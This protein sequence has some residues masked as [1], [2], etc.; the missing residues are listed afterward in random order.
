M[1]AAGTT[2]G[3]RIAIESHLD[4]SEARSL[5]EDVRAGLAAPLKEIPPKHFYDTHGALLFERIC[6]L[7]EYYQTRTERSILTAHAGRIAQLTEASELL[8]L[9]SGSAS[10]TRL[11]IAPLLAQGTLRRYIPVDCTEKMVRE[12][13][14]ELAGDYPDLEVH[15][16]IADFERHLELLPASGGR[17][18]TIFLGGTIGNFPPQ[19]RERFLAALA[20]SM[21]GDDHLLI[22]VDL[23]KDPAVLRAA[24]DDAAGVTA[25]FN[26]NL[27]RIINRELGAD[28][29]LDSFEH[30]ALYDEREQ[31]IEM[32]LRAR[33]AQR[34]RIAALAMD[35]DFAPGEEIRTE[36]SA[37]FTRARVT[38]ELDAVGLDLRAW[39]SEPGERFALALAAARGA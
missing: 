38:S 4:G 15:G 31:W 21:R 33:G 5:R 7:P 13:A 20:T 26:R 19:A 34:V 32:R 29:D 3:G 35:V 39:L 10:K 1:A 27:L 18:L 36:I 2:A 28:F 22:G 9:G 6:T 12:C 23:V 14:Q 25:Q 16:V 37:K 17:R 11:L 24:Y 8:E 30:V